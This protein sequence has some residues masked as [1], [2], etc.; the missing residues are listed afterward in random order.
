[1]TPFQ[2]EESAKAPCT[3][4]T[5]GRSAVAGAAGGSAPAPVQPALR[6]A[7]VTAAVRVIRAVRMFIGVSW[8]GW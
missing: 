1:M 5:V 8:V 3:S 6:E 4:T 7:A 2:L